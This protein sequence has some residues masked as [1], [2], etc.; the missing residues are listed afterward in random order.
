[1]P[2]G[3]AREVGAADELRSAVAR[4]S[5]TVGEIVGTLDS[6]ALSLGSMRVSGWDLLVVLAIVVF[7]FLFGKLG[8]G[9]ARRALRRTKGLDSTQE[10]L[11]EKLITIAIWA[12][13]AFLAIDLLGIDLTA[14]AV[15]SGAFGLAIGFGL[16][17]TFGNL[18]AGIILLMDKSIKPGDV[19]VI[20]DQAGQSTFGQIRKIGVRAVSLVTRDQK[21][22]LIPNENLMINQVENWSYSSRNVRIQVPVGV[23][24]EADMDRA[25]KLMLEAAKSCERVLASPPPVV[26]MKGFGD[27][28]VDFT[29]HCW[30]QDPEE[31]V[32]NVQSAVLKK[33]WRAFKDNGIEIPFPQRDIHLRSSDQI[34]RL[35][36]AI[37]ARAQT[38]ADRR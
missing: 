11:A 14:L 31:G 9:L 3:L 4:R 29:I 24:Y 2:A 10:L 12:L 26:W 37:E 22:Y 18:I 5:D 33:V 7:C 25:E 20:A 15:F 13:A 19:I 6:W 23:S 21:E 35:L 8:S 27:S 17:K 32:G 30:I 36:A 28:S 38:G 1:M 34:D 16:Q